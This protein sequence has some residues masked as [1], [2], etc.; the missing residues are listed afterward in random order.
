MANSAERT[1]NLTKRVELAS[2]ILLAVIGICGAIAELNFG[3]RPRGWLPVSGVFVVLFILTLI[4]LLAN[5]YYPGRAIKVLTVPLIFLGLPAS[6]FF[7]IVSIILFSCQ[8]FYQDTDARGIH[9]G[10]HEGENIRIEPGPLTVAHTFGFKEEADYAEVF[11]RP[12]ESDKDRVQKVSVIGYGSATREVKEKFRHND[13]SGKEVQ[14]NVEGPSPSLSA[15]ATFKVSLRENAANLPVNLISTYKYWRRNSLWWKV[16]I[17]ALR[18][19]G[20][21]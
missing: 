14:F 6:I 7:L 3:Y 1:G 9:S 21:Y 13:L 4:L 10:S 19:F 5:H 16:R 8:F 2:A 17:W 18:H 11:I 15:T 12:V 20:P